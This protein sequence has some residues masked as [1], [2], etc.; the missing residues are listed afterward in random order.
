MLSNSKKRRWF[1]VQYIKEYAIFIRDALRKLS[2]KFTNSKQHSALYLLSF[3]DVFHQNSLEVLC[4][5][6]ECFMMG[7]GPAAFDPTEL[8]FAS[9][10]PISFFPL[11]RICCY[12]QVLVTTSSY[13]CIIVFV[14]VLVYLL[15]DGRV[16]Q[17]RWSTMVSR[18]KNKPLAPCR[19]AT[20][21]TKLKY[22]V[23]FYW[24]WNILFF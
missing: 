15:L 2:N 5:P 7:D 22:F 18:C 11:Y 19:N 21:M 9:F 24:C 13:L 23:C 16:S 1:N 4:K 20:P 17:R 8:F 6:S 10:F 12:I 3:S 14:A